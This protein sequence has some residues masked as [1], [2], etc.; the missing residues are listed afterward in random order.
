VV[1][2]LINGESR[3][4]GHQIHEGYVICTADPGTRRTYQAASD[5]PSRMSAHVPSFG[6]SECFAPTC[7]THE[8]FTCFTHVIFMCITHVTFTC[9]LPKRNLVISDIAFHY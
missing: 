8:T 6:I 3:V 1:R 4:S 5:W 7:F 2:W 9:C